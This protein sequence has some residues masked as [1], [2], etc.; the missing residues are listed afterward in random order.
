MRP[1]LMPHLFNKVGDPATLTMYTA[2]GVD[3][4]GDTVWTET[5]YDFEY[6]IPSTSTNTRLP[7]DRRGELGHY[8]M[9]QL[10]F[11]VLDNVVIP[12]NTAVD[13]PPVLTHKGLD[14]EVMEMENSKIGAI[15]FLVYRKR[16]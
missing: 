14:Y 8:Y 10:E 9:M 12:E 4:Q 5:T 15:R 7:F 3:S 1:M 16:V 2:N 13:K 6:C 11:F